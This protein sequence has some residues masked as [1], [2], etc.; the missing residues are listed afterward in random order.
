MPIV[1]FS[2]LPAAFW[3]SE[4]QLRIWSFFE[5]FCQIPKK[6]SLILFSHTSIFE[7]HSGK[8]RIRIL[9]INPGVWTFWVPTEPRL[10]EPCFGLTSIYT[11]AEQRWK[12]LHYASISNWVAAARS[13]KQRIDNC[14]L[15]H[16]SSIRKSD[17]YD[18]EHQE[19]MKMIS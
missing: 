5:K 4:N 17:S 3:K 2:D 9:G 16:T 12:S 7:H 14:N 15:V 8:E 10:L 6:S 1:S 11:F 18:I 19:P 13:L